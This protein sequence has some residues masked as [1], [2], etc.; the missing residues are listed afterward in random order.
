MRQ[1]H[2]KEMEWRHRQESANTIFKM[3]TSTHDFISFY[4]I[5]FHSF[6]PMSLP[7]PLPGPIMHSIIHLFV[8]LSIPYTTSINSIF[9]SKISYPPHIC[10][11][12][13]HL[14]FDCNISQFWNFVSSCALLQSVSQPA[15]YPFRASNCCY[16][17]T[18]IVVAAANSI[19]FLKFLFHS[20]IRCAIVIHWG[21]GWAVPCV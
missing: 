16:P 9:Q 7:L 21:C 19:K 8:H 11:S 18:I 12:Y 4:S 5:Q 1:F 20:I 17:P 15:S 10:T 2:S 13:A 14:F 3:S 6:S